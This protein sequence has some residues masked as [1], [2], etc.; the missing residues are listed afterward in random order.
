[1][2]IIRPIS[3]L[4]L[5]VLEWNALPQI[6]AAEPSRAERPNIVFIMADDLG[7]A[8][9]GC[10]GQQLIQTP[11]IDKLAM[12]GIR[13]RQAYAGSTVCAPSRCCLMTGLHN[14]HGR[15]RDNLPHGV[16]LKPSDITVARVLKNAGYRTGGVGKW[17][18]GNAGT[19]GRATRQGFDTWFGYLNQ[20]DAHF[21][22]PPF[23]DDDEGRLVLPDNPR[24]KKQYSHDLLT[25]RALK[26][27]RDS[28]QPDS[29]SPA[30][31]FLYAAYT[32]PHYASPKEDETEY[33]TPSD[34]PYRAKDWDQRSKNYAAMI[35]R[36]D[37]DVGRLVSV[38]DELG[39]KEKTLIIFTSDNGTYGP[40][41]ERFKSPG[42]FRGFKRDMYEGGIR[43]P[44]IARWPGKVPANR[45][46]DE[47]IAF[48]DML[49]TF[50]ELANVTAPGNLDGRSF[51]DALFGK[52]QQSPHSFLYWDYG[53]TR[54]M[55]L[56]A[57]RMGD[58]K[59]IRNGQ[60]TKLELYNLVTDI[61][62]SNNVS[63][64]HPEIVKK[65]EQILAEQMVQ[66]PDYPIAPPSPQK[67]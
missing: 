55:F 13:F 40:A 34:E 22:Y 1:M 49:P 28:H 25:E 2:K 47:M 21:Y 35:A 15:V 54:G 20:D 19:D 26:F 29:K 3:L 56:Q 48:W 44:L 30:P 32:V 27:I 39:L 52:P 11:N 59:G 65:I 24:T 58:W 23:L 46:S 6:E 8:D 63:D 45:T 33:S 14:G 38:I 64:R 36:L 50:A 10:Y 42:P 9:L 16:F 37:K 31:F 60:G 62:E 5:I 41:P 53:H 18:L 61:S 7:Y 66:S 17:S 51:T 43:V 67:K 12:E 4:L 57:V